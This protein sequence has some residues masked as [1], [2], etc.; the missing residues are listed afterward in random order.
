M[1]ILISAD[2]HD[3]QPNLEM[4]LDY[5]DKNKIDGL[6]VCG[7]ITNEETLDLIA[8]K[9]TGLIYVI[10][11]NMDI[12]EENLIYNYKNIKYAG[13]YGTVMIDGRKIGLCHEPDYI[14]SL[15]KDNAVDPC[16][17]IF[18]GHTHKPWQDK[19]NNIAILNPGTTAG[20]FSKPT[21]AVWDTDNDNF[22]LVLIED[23]W[24]SF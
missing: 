8:K 11:G 9:F 16:E 23:L 18:F 21:F 13:R 12:Y 10:R 3:N 22:K 14:D 20:T 1:K 2:I 7:D 19:R 4:C 6:V 17:L 15:I 5:Y 24:K